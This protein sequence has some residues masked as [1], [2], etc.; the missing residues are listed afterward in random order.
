MFALGTA[1]VAA[2]ML[3]LPGLASGPAPQPAVTSVVIEGDSISSTAPD[4]SAAPQAG[5]AGGM[6]PYRWRATRPDLAIR[7]RAQ[8]SRVIGAPANADDGGNSLFGHM[9]E[10]LA[11]GPQ[12]IAAKI[13]ANDLENLTAAQLGTVY[14]ANLAA[15]RA[16]YNSGG[17]K[18]AWSAP[19]PYNTAATPG[20]NYAGFAARR[21]EL[22]ALGGSIRDPSVWSQYADFYIP[23]GETPGF[24]QP[25]N[26]A[27]FADGKHPNAT[28]QAALAAVFGA[29]MD[30]LA[31]A[32]RASS[33]RV[34]GSVWPDSETGLAS[35]TQIVRSFTVAGLAHGGIALTGGNALSVTGGGNPGLRRGGV[36]NFTAAIPGWLYNG[37]VVELRLTPS[38]NPSTATT[39]ALRIGSEMRTLTFTTAAD[40]AP[41]TYGHGD[42]VIA[43]AGGGDTQTSLTGLRF[44]DGLAVVV[45][46]AAEAGPS[47]VTLNGAPMTMRRREVA[48]FNGAI[49]LWDAPVVAGSSHGLSITYPAWTPHRVISYGTLEGGTF[50]AAAGNAPMYES[51]PHMLPAVTVPANG[52][53][54]AGFLESGGAAIAPAT[55]TSGT[56]VIAE[57]HVHAN[58][59]TFGI[60]LASRG[61]SGQAGFAFPFGSYPRVVAVYREG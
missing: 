48:E 42:I 44:G 56:T 38:A 10:D 32:S 15:I 12:L 33:T 1:L 46:R 34:Y 27:L 31:D 57:A 7:V 25:D 23:L 5:D 4:P 60:A 21:A 49:E 18:F 26:A 47:S 11:F 39:I 13:G 9:A 30:S 3:A 36:G 51:D 16:A 37:D 43:G 28:G 53:A 52:V 40:V 50:H 55:G 61:T 58:S 24:A 17:A 6:F 19:I 2:G 29:A 59:A 35:S 41:A 20:P 54:L 22:M 45:L 14:L 8:A